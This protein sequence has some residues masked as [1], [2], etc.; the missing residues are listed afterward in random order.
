M[1]T[2]INTPLNVPFKEKDEAKALGARWNP[3]AKHWYIPEGLDDGPFTKWMDG[4]VSS[5]TDTAL[6][7]LK[8]KEPNATLST[9]ADIDDINA[10]LRDAY[11]VNDD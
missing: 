2:T 7:V 10:M 1:I 4:E 6:P 11:E 9:H 3:A 8:V 5:S